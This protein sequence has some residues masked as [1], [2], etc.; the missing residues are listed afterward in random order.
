MQKANTVY[1]QALDD[2]QQPEMDVAIAEELD[3]FVERRIAE[4]GAPVD[5]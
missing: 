4:G 1:K 5:F 2:Y 3:A